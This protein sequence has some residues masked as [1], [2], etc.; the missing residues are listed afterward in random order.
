MGNRLWFKDFITALG[1]LIFMGYIFSWSHADTRSPVRLA[2][3]R[4]H[5][6]MVSKQLKG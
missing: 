4:K 6:S 5:A 3:P 1:T 2:V